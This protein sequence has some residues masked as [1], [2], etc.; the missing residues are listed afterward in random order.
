MRCDAIR[1]RLLS[2]SL[3]LFCC[4][5]PLAAGDLP[6]DFVNAYRPAL[7]IIR[8]NYTNA[9]VE[10]TRDRFF[11]QTNKSFSQRFVLRVSGTWIR[12]DATTTA[13]KGLGAEIGGTRVYL[14]T[15]DAS[16]QTFQHPGS[17]MFDTIKQDDY[18]E[19]RSRIGDV[20]PI[21]YAFAFNNRESILE[22]LLS[23]N[24]KVTSFKKGKK[25]GETMFQ[26]KYEQ[27]TDPNGRQGPWKCELL[28]SPD[29]G[30]A[31]REYS[32][33][34][35]QGNDQSTFRGKLTYGLDHNGLPLMQSIQCRQEQGPGAKL[36]ERDEINISW[37]NT[38]TPPDKFFQADSM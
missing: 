8:K 33:T 6:R 23:S 21:N 3:L 36:V 20:C 15:P 27:Q 10:G 32:R 25:S 31:L 2:V 9:T 1:L 4:A 38:E 13:Q 14:A 24:V 17:E 19:A 11:A 28:I 7:E 16:L 12:I 29:E 35:G 22:M 30:Y 26:I 34:T 5:G 37:F 18:S